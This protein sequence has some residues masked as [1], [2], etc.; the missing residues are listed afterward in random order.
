MDR[1][2][3]KVLTEDDIK[4][5]TLGFLKGYYKFRPR[6]GST[7]L[8]S[9]LR[10]VGGIVADGFLRFKKD[11]DTDFTATF[12]ATS[13]D[14]RSEVRF[15]RLETLLGWDA[16]AVGSIITTILF[17]FSYYEDLY[18]IKD[19]SPTIVFFLLVTCFVIS[20]FVT[21]GLLKSGR[22]YRY[23]YAVEQFKKYHADEQWIAIGE[24]VFPTSVDPHF[25]ELKNQCV[26]N[27]FGL[28][29]ITLDEEPLVSITPARQE[30]FGSQRKLV[31]FVT[32]NELT[33]RFQSGQY[34]DWVKWFTKGWDGWLNPQSMRNLERYRKR[35]MYQIII[36]AVAFSLIGVI[37]FQELE[38]Q[39]IKYVGQK[40]YVEEIE[41]YRA[42]K[43][44]PEPEDF[45]FIDTPFLYPLP[46]LIDRNREDIAFD[47]DPKI[48]VSEAMRL[49][50]DQKANPKPP[51]QKPKPRKQA[52]YDCDR[53]LNIRSPRYILLE[54]YYEDFETT[55][56]RIKE[57]QA[58]DLNANG[59][60]LGCFKN[61][62]TQYAVYLGMLY[63]D[64]D[65]AAT[66][67]DAVFDSMDRQNYSMS[68]SILTVEPN[69][70]VTN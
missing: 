25:L 30:L 63:K 36:T 41:G 68:I 69:I 18:T 39:R 1:N 60:W 37:Y 5:V 62:T 56:R 12:E 54:G 17:S 59:L 11:D 58:M 52:L 50:E 20:F 43:T 10:G 21:Y 26:Y 29:I 48:D 15:R 53:F 9:D 66:A 57:L 49:P 45:F 67:I 31:E 4:R 32:Q 55:N 27:G 46:L 70:K 65:E 44:I 13:Y 42:K 34:S 22:R 23:I 8:S 28:L 19:Y 40:V 7:E 35:Y 64:M 16:M 47:F 51:R 6:K 24:D 33:R 61:N 38:E 2:V 3:Q 14:T